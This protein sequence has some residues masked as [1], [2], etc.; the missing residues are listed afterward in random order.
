M[1]CVSAHV[2]WDDFFVV[3]WAGQSHAADVLR[4][5]RTVVVTD[6]ESGVSATDEASAAEENGV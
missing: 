4:A 6:T 1:S 3:R 2:G 5:L